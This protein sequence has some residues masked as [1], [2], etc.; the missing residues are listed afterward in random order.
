MRSQSYD[1]DILV[2]ILNGEIIVDSISSFYLADSSPQ[3]FHELSPCSA[4]CQYSNA[5][6]ESG[7]QCRP[8]LPPYFPCYHRS[9]LRR[10]APHYSPRHCPSRHHHS[11]PPPPRSS[12]PSSP[13][14]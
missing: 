5:C 4:E 12:H 7:H 2:D 10:P 11:P 14:P 13:P 1:C 6:R 9:C 3:H 8:A